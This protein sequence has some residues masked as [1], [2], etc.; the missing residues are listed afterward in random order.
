MKK[1]MAL[2]VVAVSSLIMAPGGCGS[3]SP[4]PPAHSGDGGE[5]EGEGNAASG[6]GE[7]QP[8]QSGEGEGQSA[9]EGEGQP[10]G[11]GEGE[12][13]PPPPSNA[14]C[15]DVPI[16]NN[17]CLPGCGN[18]KFVGQPCTKGG[19]EC[20]SHNFFAGEATFCTLD[21][22]ADAALAMCTKPCSADSDCGNDAV[23]TSDPNDPGGSKGCVPTAC[24][25][26]P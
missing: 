17:A 21:W 8:S 22:S 3:G 26:A 6:E 16:A 9:G 25:T 24:T 11:E 14:N 2:L 10:A 19:N 18:D 7:G 23:C 1:L 5:G 20:A 13:P 12:G 4:P 15:P